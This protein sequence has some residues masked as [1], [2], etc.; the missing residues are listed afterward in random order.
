[1]RQGL[2]DG[3]R[4]KL[5]MR[6]GTARQGDASCGTRGA[7]KMCA[8]G[9]ERSSALPSSRAWAL[10]P[11]PKWIEQRPPA[12]N[13]LSTLATSPLRAAP[14]SSFKTIPT[15]AAAMAMMPRSNAAAKSR[16][17]AILL[18]RLMVL[19]ALAKRYSGPLRAVV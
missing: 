3:M 4:L 12:K 15:C 6:R 10:Q 18:A 19:T 16:G 14:S 17:A 5:K 11:L 9:A 2:P 13:L 7:G 8:G 1:M